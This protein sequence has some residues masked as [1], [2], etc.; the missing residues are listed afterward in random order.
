MGEIESVQGWI[1]TKAHEIEVEDTALAKIHYKNGALSFIECSTATYPALPTEIYLHGTKGSAIMKGMHASSQNNLLITTLEGRKKDYCL[2][3]LFPAPNF[4]FG[5]PLAL[6]P[7]IKDFIESIIQ[8][9]EPKVTG[10]EGR[11]SLEI[12]RAIY[13]SSKEAKTVEFPVQDNY[14]LINFMNGKLT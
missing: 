8:D 3:P 5:N 1:T 12:I 4:R 9:R 14:G 2:E 6:R 11:K 13:I 7:V 10:E